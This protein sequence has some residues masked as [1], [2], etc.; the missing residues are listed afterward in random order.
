LD[1]G[2]RWGVNGSNSD[3]VILIKRHSA[4]ILPFHK[5]GDKLGY[6]N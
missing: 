1:Y 5:K 6:R 4:M 3:E 2:R